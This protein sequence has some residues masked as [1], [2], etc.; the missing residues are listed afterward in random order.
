MKTK[1]WVLFLA[2]ALVFGLFCG[3]KNKVTNPVDNRA[4]SNIGIN[5]TTDN[6]YGLD[7]LLIAPADSAILQAATVVPATPPKYEWSVG[8]G[9]IF[10]LIPEVGDSSSVIAMALGDSGAV[11]TI[12]VKDI[13][14][15]QQKTLTAKV[16][17]W[18]DMQSFTYVGTLNK[19]HYFL[20]KEVAD[21]LTAEIVCEKNHGHLV[22]ITSKEENDMVKKARTMAPKDVWIGLKD[23]WDPDRKKKVDLK[24]TEWVNHEKTTYTNW[25]SGQP[26]FTSPD[27]AWDIK[28]FCMML[29]TGKWSDERQ[30]SKPYVLEIP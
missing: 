3:K 27:G 20:S 24:W 23:Q 21:W 12:T 25:A 28:Q 29:S 13:A 4:G 26:D 8:N 1:R 14:N 22:T 19:H 11:T 9:A 7:S 17:I 2:L 10:Q 15:N 5:A 30:M 6:P 16:A 18:A